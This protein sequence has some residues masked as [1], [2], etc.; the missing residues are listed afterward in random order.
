MRLDALGVVLKIVVPHY[1]TW[2]RIDDLRSTH[3]GVTVRIDEIDPAVDKGTSQVVSP[4]CQ[5]Q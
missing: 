4:D 5:C 1:R 3:A 2:V